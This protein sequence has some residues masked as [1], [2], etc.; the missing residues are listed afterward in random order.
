MD[1]YFFC[2]LWCEWHLNSVDHV[3]PNIICLSLWFSSSHIKIKTTITQTIYH[4]VILIRHLIPTFNHWLVYIQ[5]RCAWILLRWTDDTKW[6]GV[7][8]FSSL[9]F[10]CYG[11]M[12]WNEMSWKFSVKLSIAWNEKFIHSKTNKKIHSLL[13]IAVHIHWE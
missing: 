10:F 13:W 2:V 7:Y 8:D 9:F 6:N 1:I 11:V 3:H 12:N 5:M 4:I